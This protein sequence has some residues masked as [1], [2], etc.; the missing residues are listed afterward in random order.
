M[1]I[2]PLHLCAADSLAEQFMSKYSKNSLRRN[3]LS[4]GPIEPDASKGI[5][6]ILQRRDSS[7]SDE[8]DRDSSSHEEPETPGESFTDYD[9]ETPAS[10]QKRKRTANDNTHDTREKRQRA[11][12]EDTSVQCRDSQNRHPGFPT[13]A[14][15]TSAHHSAKPRL[16]T[17]VQSAGSTKHAALQSSSTGKR[18]QDDGEHQT[19]RKRRGATAKPSVDTSDD[20]ATASKSREKSYSK[21]G[22]RPIMTSGRPGLRSSA[23]IANTSSKNLGDSKVDAG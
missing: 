8:H 5:N 13:T 2:A 17:A 19:A 16:S 10:P 15:R 22:D 21:R 3:I 18:K 12:E 6:T 9:E 23:R 11:A 20:D 14:P 7:S 4:S 1:T